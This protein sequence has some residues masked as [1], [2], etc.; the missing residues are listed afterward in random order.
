MLGA[1]TNLDAP[2][3]NAS[4][5]AVSFSVSPG[6]SFVVFASDWFQGA[7][8]PNGLFQPGNQF[9]LTIGFS[10]G[11]SATAVT[12]IPGNNDAIMLSYNGPLQDRAADDN[13]AVKAD[14]FLDPTFTVSFPWAGDANGG[15][16]AA[17]QQRRRGL[18]YEFSNGILDIGRRDESPEPLVQCSRRFRELRGSCR[19]YVYDFRIGLVAR[20]A[21]SEWAVSKGER[22]Y[23]NDWF[24][25]WEYRAG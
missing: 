1:A 2:L 22:I 25:R 15:F 10:D 8:F 9:T 3:Y 5:D 18:G 12:T 23:S 16:F 13:H 4:N 19:R 24:Q 21:V 7:P 14:G 11:S 17:R 6:G 20:R